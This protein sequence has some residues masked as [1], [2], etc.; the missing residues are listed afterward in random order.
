MLL[1]KILNI[2]ISISIKSDAGKFI[3]KKWCW[4]VLCDSDSDLKLTLTFSDILQSDKFYFSVRI[5]VFK[6]SKKYSIWSATSSDIRSF[7]LTRRLLAAVCKI[8]FYQ[9]QFLP[10]QTLLRSDAWLNLALQSSRLFLFLFWNTN[11][12]FIVNVSKIQVC[13]IIVSMSPPVGKSPRN[14]YIGNLEV[15]LI[16]GRPIDSNMI[17]TIHTW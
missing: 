15:W 4:L 14:R 12:F 9:T 16:V 3:F 10:C 13:F 8:G 6:K 2:S 5:W 17:I 11:H 1:L 7:L